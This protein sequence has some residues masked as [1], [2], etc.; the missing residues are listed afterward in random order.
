MVGNCKYSLLVLTFSTSRS[1]HTCSQEILHS[2]V[3]T[4]QL[5]SVLGLYTILP[6]NQSNC[7]FLFRQKSS[8]WMLSLQNPFHKSHAEVNCWDPSGNNSQ[9][10]LSDIRVSIYRAETVLQSEASIRCK[11]GWAVSW[12]KDT[13]GQKSILGFVYCDLWTWY[14][15]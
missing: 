10:I 8:F 13:L 4:T 1:L 15:Q 7:V 5:V 3:W 6:V 14:R 9:L 2:V 11:E 12:T